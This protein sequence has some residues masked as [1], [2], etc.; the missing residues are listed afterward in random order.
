MCRCS[1]YV[2][3][4]A[5]LLL[6][7]LLSCSRSASGPV[8]TV[9]PATPNPS[10]W[11][12]A[13][14]N[15]PENALTSSANTGG[16]EQSFRFFFVPTLPGTE[17]RI[18]LSNFFGTT[19]ISVGAARLA[20]A[21]EKGAAI[22]TA[23]DA[24]LTF[25]GSS[26][27]TI[28][29]GGAVISDPVNITYSYGQKMAVSMY[30]QGTFPSLTQHDAQVET[31]YENAP[32]GGNATSDASGAS[33]SQTSGEW[34]LLSGMDVYGAYQGTV[35]I[36]GS[37]TVDGHNSNFGNTESYPTANVAVDGQ[38]RDRPS[39]W[40]ARELLAAGYQLGVANAGVLADPAGPNSGATPANGIADGIDRVN[41][42]VL[43][44]PGIKAVII[45]LGS[46]DIRSA[47]CKSAPDIENSLTNI[48]AQ[49]QAVGV[50]VILATIPPAAYCSTPGTANFGPVPSPADPYAGDINPGPENPGGAQRKILNTWIRTSGAQLPGV[51]GIADFDKALLDPEHPDFMMP[52]L[53]S[54]DNFHPNGFGYG[55]QSA[56]IPL[57]S[58]LGY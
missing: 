52:A 14:S 6:P 29:P 54:G 56:A 4:T 24:A 5:T 2:L 57:Q 15:S 44:L 51:V 10:I 12:V 20:I 43:Q 47:D 37:S 9:S 25:G 58:I 33:L 46:I 23:H 8:S 42:D 34:F 49:A 36:L 40:L 3:L 26:S 16:Q 31:N 45:Y 27:I 39:D 48:V 11:A 18:H 41:R 30:L 7:L 32:G 55:V 35:A 38:D 19:P 53:N 50:R 13:W 21:T 17:E 28:P 22:D 1:P